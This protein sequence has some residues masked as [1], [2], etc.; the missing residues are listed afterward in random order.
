MDKDEQDWKSIV[1]IGDW[2]DSPDTKHYCFSGHQYQTQGKLYQVKQLDFRP[3]STCVIVNGDWQDPTRTEPEN[4]WL[5]YSKVIVRNGQIIWQSHLEL[6]I[7]AIPTPE[8]AEHNK[9][10]PEHQLIPFEQTMTILEIHIATGQKDNELLDIIKRLEYIQ[11]KHDGGNG[12]SPREEQTLKL[13][14]QRLD[15]ITK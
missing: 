13:A 11:A 8:L 14:Y 4:V 1:Q 2:V 5:G 12:L 10:N 3:D 15:E 9:E 7:K 6:A